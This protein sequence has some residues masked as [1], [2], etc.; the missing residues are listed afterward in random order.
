MQRETTTFT[1]EGT[2][3]VFTLKT[4]LTQ[5]EKRQIESL[6][7]TVKDANAAGS[8]MINVYAAMQD[9]TIEILVTKLNDITDSKVILD[10]VLNYP[11]TVFASF[12]EKVKSITD[13]TEKKTA[14]ATS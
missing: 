9:K 3:D 5:L 2:T 11:A 4:Y 10:T 14:S 13:G 8:E 12:Y 6:F 1:P 7:A